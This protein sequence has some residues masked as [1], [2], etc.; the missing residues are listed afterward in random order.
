[1]KHADLPIGFHPVPGRDVDRARLPA[2]PKRRRLRLPRPTK[3][4]DPAYRKAM[5]AR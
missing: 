1:M 3:N 4:N 5:R 2:E